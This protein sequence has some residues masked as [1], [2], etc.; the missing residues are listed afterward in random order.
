[1]EKYFIIDSHAHIIPQLSGASGYSSKEDHLDVSQRSMHEHLAQPARKKKDNSIVNKKLW[2]DTYGDKGKLNVNFK[3][4]KY[5]RF[6]WI[7]DDE[8]CYIQY[9]PTYSKNMDYT[10][11][12]LKIMMDYAGVNKAVLQCG[13]VY[14]NLNKYYLSQIK[15]NKLWNTLF[16]PLLRINEKNASTKKELSYLEKYIKKYNFNGLWF[17]SDKSSFTNQYDELWNKVSEYNIPVFLPFFPDEQWGERMSV[18]DKFIEK[19]PNIPCVLPQ[20]FPLSA[21]KKDSK[22]ILSKKIKN[23]IMK[24]NVYIEIVYPIGRGQI[25]E[26]PFKIS[27]EA[28]KLLYNEFGAKKL[29]WGSDIPMIE[30]YCSYSQSLNYITNYC[31]WINNNDLKLIL[32]QNLQN[33]FK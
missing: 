25:E 13:G 1:M 18:I 31:E 9:L 32:G 30:R 14:G 11:D 8:E 2:D 28:I 23:I 20:A 24:G 3:V 26:Y 15:N 17:I 6:E 33:I 4:G 10:V 12:Q 5:G 29:V 19:Y 7:Q 27:H 21:K 22:I 16:Y